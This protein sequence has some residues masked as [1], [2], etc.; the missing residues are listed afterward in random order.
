MQDDEQR[1]KSLSD[2]PEYTGDD[3]PEPAEDA[4]AKDGE[5]DNVTELR[6]KGAPL[7]DDESGGAPEEDP[8][9][10]LELFVIEDGRDLSIGQL[11][12][13]GTPIEIRFVVTG[14]SIPNSEGGLLDPYATSHI[15]IGDYVVDHVKPQYIRDSE[16]RVE[17]VVLY[18]TLKPRIIQQATSVRGAELLQQAKEAKAAADA[19]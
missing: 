16:Q 18:Q 10:Q 9:D 11:R 19:A 17:K 1:G 7:G 14:K 12:K 6:K 3:A 8:E 4:R 5:P 2:A 15:L 13:R